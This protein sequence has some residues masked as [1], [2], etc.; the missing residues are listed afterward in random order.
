MTRN[1]YMFLPYDHDLSGV[2]GRVR[3]PDGRSGALPMGNRGRQNL[4]L[5]GTVL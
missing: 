3:P 5:T 1:R 4:G 2:R